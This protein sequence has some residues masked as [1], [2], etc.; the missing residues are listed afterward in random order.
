MKEIVNGARECTAKY[1]GVESYR[2]GNGSG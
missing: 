2:E 1:I